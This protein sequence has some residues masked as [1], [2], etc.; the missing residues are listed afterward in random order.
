MQARVVGTRH[1][2][3]KTQYE[4]PAYV[5]IH[6]HTSAYVSIRGTRASRRRTNL[7]HSIGQRWHSIRQHTSAYVSI[8][9]NTQYEPPASIL[10]DQNAILIGKERRVSVRIRQHSSAYVSIRQH[11]SAYASIRR[12]SRNLW[13]RLEGECAHTSAYVSIRQHT[14]ADEEAVGTCGGVWRV[15]VL[16]LN[17]S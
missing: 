2:R 4:P 6:Q 15:R 17:S 12:G 5:R 9:F 1:T 13:G 16:P 10:S 3:F 14:P 7:R 11:T 8:R